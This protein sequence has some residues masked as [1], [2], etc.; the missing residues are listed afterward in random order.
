M[1]GKCKAITILAMSSQH[2]MRMFAQHLSRITPKLSS[3]LLSLYLAFKDIKAFSLPLTKVDIHFGH[4][5][6]YAVPYPIFWII[7]ILHVDL[8]PSYTDKF[9]ESR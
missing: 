9:L 6:M 7:F 1:K 8:E 3:S 2:G 5:R 4:G